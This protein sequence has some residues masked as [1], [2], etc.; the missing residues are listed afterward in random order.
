MT[1]WRTQTFQKFNGNGLELNVDFYTGGNVSPTTR[2]WMH[3]LTKRN[4]KEVYDKD[5][6]WDDEDKIV[7][8]GKRNEIF[9]RYPGV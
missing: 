4:M 7:N 3:S 1:T 5:Y 8:Y 2:R 6:G 9:G